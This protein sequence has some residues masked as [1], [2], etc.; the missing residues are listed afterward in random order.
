MKMINKNYHLSVITHV[1]MSYQTKTCHRQKR[2]KIL[3]KKNLKKKKC[4]CSLVI[5]KKIYITTDN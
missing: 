1:K 4:L 2:N 5:K 3:T